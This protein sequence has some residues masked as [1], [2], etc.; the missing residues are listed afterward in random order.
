MTSHAATPRRRRKAHPRALPGPTQADGFLDCV[1]PQ[2]ARRQLR[3]SF[4][5]LAILAAGALAVV[6]MR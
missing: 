4:A 6:A 2:D 1:S 5:L 3:V